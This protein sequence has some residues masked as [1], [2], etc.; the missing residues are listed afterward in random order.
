MEDGKAS[1]YTCF[2]TFELFDSRSAI[3]Y[4]F[5][6]M[7]L[8][9]QEKTNIVS[10]YIKCH[11]NSREARRQYRIKYPERQLPGHITFKRLFDKFNTTGSLSRKK[12]TVAANEN[13]NINV[14]LYFTGK[15]PIINAFNK[16]THNIPFM[17]KNT[18]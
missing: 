11:K 10:I 5:T 4:K 16:F 12:R 15:N 1:S 6:N 17:F 18:Q 7:P 3:A 14:A 2:A 8:S 9:M 13:E